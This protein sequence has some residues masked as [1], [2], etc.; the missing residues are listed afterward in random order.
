M[1]AVLSNDIDTLRPLM[2]KV[3][4]ALAT[5]QPGDIVRIST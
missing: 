5:L 3:R 2:P 1:L 4:E